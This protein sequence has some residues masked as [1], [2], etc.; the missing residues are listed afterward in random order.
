[1]SKKGH[2]FPSTHKT[3]YVSD[4]PYFSDP[5][6]RILENVGLVCNTDKVAGREP[7]KRTLYLFQCSAVEFCHSVGSM[8]L[9][10]CH[11]RLFCC[12]VLECIFHDGRL[13]YRIRVF[14]DRWNNP[15]RIF[16][17]GV[18]DLLTLDEAFP[19]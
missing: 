5:Y 18:D 8:P 3:D 7:G 13:S 2:K 15:V 6:G 12:S 9:Y 16:I 17:V 10:L 4:A 11:G 1:M 14:D 19:V